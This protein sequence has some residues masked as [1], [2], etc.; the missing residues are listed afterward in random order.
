M[1]DRANKV[2]REI[3]TPESYRVERLRKYRMTLD[4]YDRML[5]DQNGV[6]AI[7][8]G[9]QDWKGRTLLNVDHCHDT[10]RVRGLLCHRC[11]TAIG[12]MKDDV[13]RLQSAIN[14]LNKS[15]RT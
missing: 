14:Y 15:R 11:N 3:S 10:G 13:V 12:L 6:C 1:R 8:G 9:P 5:S 4:D 7:C 2:R